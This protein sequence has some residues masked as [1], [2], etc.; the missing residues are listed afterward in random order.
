MDIKKLLNTDDQNLLSENAGVQWVPEN[1]REV[2]LPY[3]SN[4]PNEEEEGL[5]TRRRKAKEVVDG[6]TKIIEDSKVLEGEIEERCKN[7]KV[8]LNTGQHLSVIEAI[9][10][11][12]GIR[13]EE[14]TFDMYKI[15]VKELGKIAN[16]TGEP[17]NDGNR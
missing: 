14:V 9:G 12:F 15:C 6:Y 7:V 16:N 3:M 2:L 17:N 11:V 5:D 1:P 13:S 8:P 10:R 4:V